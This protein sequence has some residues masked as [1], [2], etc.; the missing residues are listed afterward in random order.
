MLSGTSCTKCTRLHEHAY[1]CAH[2]HTQKHSHAHTYT[3][4]LAMILLQKSGHDIFDNMSDNST[5]RC[6]HVPCLS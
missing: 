1:T 6:P 5:K 2:M 4:K 3:H